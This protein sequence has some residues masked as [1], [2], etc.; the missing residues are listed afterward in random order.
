M[1]TFEKAI[2]FQILPIESSSQGASSP[3]ASMPLIEILCIDD[4]YLVDITEVS[5]P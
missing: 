3:S 2:T 5:G 4:I 1:S